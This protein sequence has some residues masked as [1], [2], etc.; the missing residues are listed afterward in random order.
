MA[1]KTKTQLLRQA[2]PL[3]DGLTF[4]SALEVSKDYGDVLLP[5]IVAKPPNFSLEQARIAITEAMRQVFLWC[6]KHEDVFRRLSDDQAFY[7]VILADW[8]SAHLASP[9]PPA[10][11]EKLVSLF[12]GARRR[13]EAERSSSEAEEGGEE[14]GDADYDDEEKE[15]EEEE[16]KDEEE[17]E[18]K[19]E[20]DEE[21]DGGDEDDE[22]G[23][24]AS[25][26]SGAAAPA[27]PSVPNT[28]LTMFI[29]R[30]IAIID[31]V[32]ASR[33][34]RRPANLNPPAGVDAISTLGSRTW[35]PAHF[36][37]VD[38][39]IMAQAALRKKIFGIDHM[40]KV[41]EDD[42][43]TYPHDQTPPLDVRSFLC[44][45]AL[46]ETGPRSPTSLFL[47]PIG[48]MEEEDRRE[49]YLPT[50]HK[51]RLYATV[52]EFIGYAH[53]A[54]KTPAGGAMKFHAVGLLTPWF[55]STER[56]AAMAQDQDQPI[57]TVWQGQC[58]RAGSVAVLTRLR[59]VGER[60]TCRLMLFT[61]GQPH[62]FRPSQPSDRIDQQEAWLKKLA[63][64]L[65]A[66]FQIDE[67]WAGGR[68]QNHYGPSL[69]ERPV[70]ADSVESSS[71]ILQEIM[72]DVAKL[73][74]D[75][76]ALKKRGFWSMAI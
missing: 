28:G 22:E 44:W 74:T 62:Y 36:S 70:T 66:G 41:D 25:G 6:V 50:G 38:V 69:A 14:V 47:A 34:T 42:M 65:A 4:E 23:G 52:D 18:E 5:L 7:F 9:F 35:P 53:E 57:P 33:A 19:D 16:E 64:K 32:M 13:F 54:F 3:L 11:I 8:N 72:M 37:A 30:W 58:F 40:H 73:P 31:D 68:A 75:E 21:Y 17:D 45:M 10:S 29:D 76:A 26:S 12:V 56:V 61:P 55:F 15:V 27:A 48:F 51:S 59:R 60:H 1:P 63:R 20:E 39:A 24:D 71:E 46:E 67:A 2:L 49:W 43:P